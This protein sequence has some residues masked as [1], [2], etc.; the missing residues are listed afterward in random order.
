MSILH[1]YIS[2]EILRYLGI[3]LAVVVC[4]YVVFDFIEKI[5]DIPDAG[6]PLSESVGFFLLRIPFIVALVAPLGL[7]MAVLIA[8]GLMNRNNETIALKSGGVSIYYLLRPVLLIGLLSSVLLFFLSEIIVPIANARAN[9]IWSKREAGKDS[10]V[11]LSE[12]N[13][14]IK[15]G[16]LIA[17]IKYYNPL[18]KTMYGVTLNH[19]DGDFRLLRRVDAERGVYEQGKWVL[20]S[21]I[22]QRRNQGD[23]GF[24]HSVQ[25]RRV[26]SLNL[27]PEDLKEVAKKSAEMSFTELLAYIGKAEAAGYDVTPYRV[28]LHAKIAFPLVCIIMC[29]VSAGIALRGNIKEGLPVSI[30]YGIGTALLYWILHSLCVSLGY[31]AMLPAF[32][33]AWAADLVFVCLGV[34]LLLNAE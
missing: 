19:L 1:S 27:L 30:A 17:H 13:I 33:A 10:A 18:S 8:L 32:V 20:H 23:R 26:V 2:R 5:D 11:S 16:S 9:S 28:D 31:G 29:M 22:E 4:M 25:D 24:T 14:W 34:L 7:L 3:V 6:L 15:D 21:I 12:K